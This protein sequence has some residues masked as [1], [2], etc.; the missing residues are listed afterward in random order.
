MSILVDERFAGSLDD[1]RAARAAT[2]LPLLAKGF[3]TRGAAATSCAGAGADAALLILRDLDDRA[4]PRCMAHAHASSGSTRSSRRTTPTSSTARSRLGATGIGVNARDLDTF[5]IDR[6]AQLELVAQRA[7]RPGRDRARAAIHSR[8]QG[9]AAELAGADA[10]LVGTALMRAPDP[11][12]KLRELLVAA[13]RQGLRADARGG[14]RRRRRGRRRP[15]RLH[16]R[17]RR[18]RAGAGRCCPSRTRCSR[19]R[20]SSASVDDDRRRPRPVLRARERPP[21]PRRRAA[22][23]RRAG[24]ARRRPAVAARRTRAPRARARDATG[25]VMLA[26]GLG[27][28]NVARGDRG[29]SGPGRSTRARASSRAPGVKDHDKVRAYVEAAR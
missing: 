6:R 4:P 12:A 7:A 14:R 13:A 17:A 23:R 11:A 24:R 21:R 29:A 20:S 15:A 2:Q 25:R 3:F 19:S 16:P 18:A 8:A 22:P 9:A 27:A 28:D 10:I 1:L 26:G 5:S